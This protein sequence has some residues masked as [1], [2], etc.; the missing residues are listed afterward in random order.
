MDVGLQIPLAAVLGSG[1][2]VAGWFIN[3]ALN[4]RRDN[5]LRREKTKDF[6]RA[7]A[8]EIK[9]YLAN[10][11]EDNLKDFGE[12]MALK[13]RKSSAKKPFI[14]FI[15]SEQHDTVFKAIVAEIHIL[16]RDVID[17][18][19]R[20][21]EQVTDIEKII[22]DMRS[23]DYTQLQDID[24]AALIFEDYVGMKLKAIRLGEEAL[25]AIEKQAKFTKLQLITGSWP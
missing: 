22:G 5:R 23:S 21:Y 3:S 24:A 8:A 4:R 10:L 20:Y 11:N 19:V 17:P 2:V 15:A 9:A 13:I 12:E 18:V 25:S 1:V 6:E 7:I 14:P 16:P